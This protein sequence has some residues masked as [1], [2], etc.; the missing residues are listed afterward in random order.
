[1]VVSVKVVEV[2]SRETVF[3]DISEEQTVRQLKSLLEGKGLGPVYRQR[4]AHAG[5]LL[6]DDMT[7]SE[8]GIASIPSVVLSL[9][10]PAIGDPTIGAMSQAASRNNTADPSESEALNR[11]PAYTY[12]EQTVEE[13]DE[14]ATDA[15]VPTCRICHGTFESHSSLP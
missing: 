12:H 7:I 4:L 15:N 2:V 8:C 11:V 6:N 10:P 14:D 3:V 5:K 1:M 13:A 9:K